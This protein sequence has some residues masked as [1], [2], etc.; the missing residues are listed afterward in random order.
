MN[1]D[2]LDRAIRQVS[3]GLFWSEIRN[4]QE[5]SLFDSLSATRQTRLCPTDH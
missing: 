2:Q 4:G 3:G 1:L 5:Q